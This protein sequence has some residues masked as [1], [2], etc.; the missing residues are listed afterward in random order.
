MI[1]THWREP[2]EPLERELRLLVLAR[3]AADL[4]ERTRV[5]EALP[6]SDDRQAFLLKLSDV[7]RPLNDANQIQC[8]AARVLGEHLDVDW[9]FYFEIEPGGEYGLV[10]QDHAR[11][12]APS[13][14][15]RYRLDDTP[16]ATNALR[17]G[18]PWQFQT[19]RA[20]NC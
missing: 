15:G 18:R 19:W 1:A 14:A 16:T 2:H 5:E 6:R 13:L 10:R 3:Q 17:A 12:G 4:I 7:L 11:G 20:A 8:A 9:A